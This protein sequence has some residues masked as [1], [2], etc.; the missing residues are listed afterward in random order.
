DHNFVLKG[1]GKTPVLA[2]QVREPKSGR[3]MEMFT[4]EPGVQLYTGNF[5]DGKLK[6]KGGVV[7]QKQQGFCLE[8]QHFPDSVNHP[9]FPS[10]I[11]QPG[12]TYSQTTIY[13][14]SAK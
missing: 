14:F 3:M 10:T 6:G 4:T 12:K 11:L 7:Y 13:K 2:A 9:D 1:D 5:L 8:A